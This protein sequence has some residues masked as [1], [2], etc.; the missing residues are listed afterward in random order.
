[1]LEEQ[2]YLHCTY[3]NLT[4]LIKEQKPKPL[5][6]LLINLESYSNTVVRGWLTITNVSVFNE[7]FHQKKHAALSIYFQVNYF[8]GV[9]ILY[10]PCWDQGPTARPILCVYLQFGAEGVESQLRRTSI[11]GSVCQ[12]I[13]LW[14]GLFNRAVSILGLRD[15]IIAMSGKSTGLLYL[16]HSKKQRR[17]FRVFQVKLTV[18]SGAPT[19]AFPTKQTWVMASRFI[20]LDLQVVEVENNIIQKIKEKNKI[21]QR[22]YLL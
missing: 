19:A 14:G 6:P 16:C 1:M 12:S 15:H 8:K 4:A 22:M 21:K 10:H 20:N 11:A 7:L 5:R 13:L 17:E 3:T 9:S 2:S 18:G